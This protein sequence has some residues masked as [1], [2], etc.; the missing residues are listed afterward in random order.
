[1][2]KSVC[3]LI[4]AVLVFGM[5]GA[6]SAY[7]FDT[8]TVTLNLFVQGGATSDVTIPITGFTAPPGTITSASLTLVAYNVHGQPDTVSVDPTDISLVLLC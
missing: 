5:A 3:F 4:A 7:L 6:A 2:K 8:N 1:M